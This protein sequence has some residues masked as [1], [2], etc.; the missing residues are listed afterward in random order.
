ML[1][2][3]A[4][5]LIA[6][7][8][9]NLIT[10]EFVI[11]ADSKEVFLTPPDSTKI[12]IPVSDFDSARAFHYLKKQVEFGPRT[13]NSIGHN[14]TKSF[15]IKTLSKLADT[16]SEDRF[17]KRINDET[18]ILTNIFAIFKGHSKKILLLGAH[19]DTR[20]WADKDSNPANHQ[21]PILGANDGASGVAVLMEI[22]HVL[23]KSKPPYTVILAFFDGEDLG[24][25]SQPNNFLIGSKRFAANMGSLRPHEA[26]II[27]MIGDKDLQ[28]NSEMISITAAPD[29]WSRVLK[30]ADEVGA[31]SI[32]RGPPIEI[33]DDHLP[34]IYQGVKAIDLI[35]FTYP[36][37]HT[38]AD[39]PDKCSPISLEIVGKTILQFTYNGS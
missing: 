15:I 7:F 35:D 37:W 17:T 27:D 28:I 20:P 9:F 10:S 13:P 12:H 36:H 16:V 31:K 8:L 32:F 3:Y 29:L 39:T 24:T 18:Y 1:K 33:I 25:N 38:L 6:I 26:I 5:Q 11:A 21:K 23:N 22:A 30:A 14:K 19:W 34:L 4:F 2:F